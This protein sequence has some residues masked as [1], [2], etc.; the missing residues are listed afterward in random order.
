MIYIQRKS[1]KLEK[2]TIIKKSLTDAK[3][4]LYDLTFPN[5]QYSD[6]YVVGSDETWELQDLLLFFSKDFLIKTHSPTF[7]IYYVNGEIKKP[8][9]KKDPEFS[10]MFYRRLKNKIQKEFLEYDVRILLQYE[11]SLYHKNIDK[12]KNLHAHERIMI[13]LYNDTIQM[14]FILNSKLDI[15]DALIKSTLQENVQYL[16]LFENTKTRLNSLIYK[17]R[18]Y[19]KQKEIVE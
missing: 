10:V 15:M 7:D 5:F 3:F 14:D 16:S 18:Y 13:S 2:S 8:Q 12:N 9:R 17:Q 11:S 1:K 19:Y 4:Y 6:F